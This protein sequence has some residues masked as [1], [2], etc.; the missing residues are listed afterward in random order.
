MQDDGKTLQWHLEIVYEQSGRMPAELDIPDAPVELLYLWGYFLEMSK[1]RTC[2]AMA[3]NPLSDT[4]ILAWQARKKITL[5]HFESECIDAL[6]GVYMAHLSSK[7]T[8][9]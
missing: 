9:K 4:E 2:G 5:D 7:K 6:D 1:K 8:K 3:V